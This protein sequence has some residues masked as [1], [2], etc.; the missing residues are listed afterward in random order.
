M[1]GDARCGSK[2]Y[3]KSTIYVIISLD[4]VQR[5]LKKGASAFPYDHSE[6]ARAP[7]THEPRDVVR[8]GALS[9]LQKPLNYRGVQQTSFPVFV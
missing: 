9:L 2:L 6:Q 7:H 5:T 8:C 1:N 4:L 3:L